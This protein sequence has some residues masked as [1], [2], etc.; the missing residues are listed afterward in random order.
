MILRF[1]HKPETQARRRRK[2]PLTGA[3][4]TWVD[5]LLAGVNV[6]TIVTNEAKHGQAMLAGQAHG[7]AGRSAHRGQDGNAGDHGLLHQLET[8]STADQ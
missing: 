1:T 3:S 4:G 7:Q 8:C 2:R 5:A 6:E